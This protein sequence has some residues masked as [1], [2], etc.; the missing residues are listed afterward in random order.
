[1]WLPLWGCHGVVILGKRK[2]QQ[3]LGLTY[4]GAGAQGRG[5]LFG[6]T[7][8]DQGAGCP[9]L[10]A[11]L[12]LETE[13]QRLY[14]EHPLCTPPAPFGT[15]WSKRLPLPGPQA[16]SSPDML[17]FSNSLQWG[18]MSPEES[19]DPRV[20]KP[21]LPLGMRVPQNL[22]VRVHLPRGHPAEQAVSRQ[23]QPRA[24][25]PSGPRGEP[26]S[27][28]HLPLPFLPA[29]GCPGRSPLGSWALSP[30]FPAPLG[31]LSWGSDATPPG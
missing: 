26:P 17:W 21:L 20:T 11:F 2:R 23:T 30:P 27:P 7:L 6:S 28:V 25:G 16:L 13:H 18:L 24:W 1:M 9:G 14:D 5:V 29:P 10:L 22:G 31:A 19:L 15:C 8:Q 12:V 3:A 4:F